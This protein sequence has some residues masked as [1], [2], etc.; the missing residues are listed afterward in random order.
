MKFQSRKQHF[1]TP[2][3]V[4]CRGFSKQRSCDLADE[5]AP[6]FDTVEHWGDDEITA[7]KPISEHDYGRAWRIVDRY[8]AKGV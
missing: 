6:H 7:Y 3:K 1:P 8:G 4:I 2:L 5:L